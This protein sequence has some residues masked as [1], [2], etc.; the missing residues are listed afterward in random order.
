LKEQYPVIHSF[1][2]KVSLDIGGKI[3]RTTVELL[4]REESFF[5]SMFS[6][7]VVIDK[8][9]F[10][11]SY[12]VDRSP[13][14]FPMILEFLR[15]GGIKTVD[16]KKIDKLDKA[17]LLAEAEFYCMESLVEYLGGA[18]KGKFVDYSEMTWNPAKMSTGINLSN[19]NLTAVSSGSCSHKTVLG[20]IPIEKGVCSWEVRLNQIADCYSAVGLVGEKFNY[21]S[22]NRMGVD[23]DSWALGIYPGSHVESS[24]K[25]IQVPSRL[26]SGQ[27][28]KGV[29]DADAGTLKFFVDGVERANFTN[30][31][32][33]GNAYIAL[34]VCELTQG[35]YTLQNVGSDE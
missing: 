35:G 12:F 2:P 8:D 9:P 27:V 10:D 1:D 17:A 16:R 32:F 33:E 26:N 28:V 18:R 15:T 25:R 22:L 23:G 7:R 20:S 34:T 30:V 13:E 4:T 31:E 29:Y 6:G 24:A 5:S 11:D 21:S 14:Y 3:F 19:G